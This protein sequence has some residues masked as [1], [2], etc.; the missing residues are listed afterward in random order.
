MTDTNGAPPEPVDDGKVGLLIDGRDVRVAPGT[1][2]WDAATQVGIHIP[3]YCAHPKM[4]PVAVCRMCLVTVEK[5]P[6]LQPACATV[7]SEGMV[8][9]T[10]TDQVAKAREGML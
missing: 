7:V 3:V 8:V 10:Q 4:E 5:L 9:H 1:L 6:K 2:L